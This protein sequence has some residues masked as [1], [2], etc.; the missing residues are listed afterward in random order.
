MS[1]SAGLK[2]N[3]VDVVLELVQVRDNLLNIRWQLGLS[4]ELTLI[5][6]NTDIHS[7]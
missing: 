5:I 6:H 2:T 4:N 1:K 7:A 3:D